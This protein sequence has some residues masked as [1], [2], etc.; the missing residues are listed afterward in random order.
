MESTITK[1]QCVKI[2]NIRALKKYDPI[3]GLKEWLEDPENVY[4]GRAQRT[5]ITQNKEHLGCDC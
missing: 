3:W 4:V 5:F 1:T 2:G